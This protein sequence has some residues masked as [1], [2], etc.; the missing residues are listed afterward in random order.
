VNAK[1]ATKHQRVEAVVLNSPLP[2]SKQ[3]ICYNLL[4]VSPTTIE[5]VLADMVKIGLIDKTGSGRG[6]KYIKK[7]CYAASESWQDIVTIHIKY[8]DCKKNT[9]LEVGKFAILWNIFEHIKFG[10]DC[11]L[12][13]IKNLESEL[14]KL[15]REQPFV[16]LATTLRMR[17]KEQGF[18]IEEYV[19][20]QLFKKGHKPKDSS[21]IPLT[22]E[23]INS[24]RK[25]NQ[26]GAMYA[27]YRIRN[28]MFHGTKAPYAL[29]N[30]IELF[31][32]ANKVLESVI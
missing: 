19:E 5:A 32:D 24:P 8:L 7:Q 22:I 12:D 27:I 4:D 26:V 28:N 6:T 1:K 30:Q 13:D 25:N 3:E 16:K 14:M 17:A 23:F 2:I 10:E 21:I 18:T 15:N 31:E 20:T 11:R 29:D 9:V